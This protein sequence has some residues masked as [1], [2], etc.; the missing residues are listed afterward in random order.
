MYAVKPEANAEVHNVKNIKSVTI[1]LYNLENTQE[2]MVNAEMENIKIFLWYMHMY[3]SQFKPLRL[4]G[5]SGKLKYKKKYTL[6]HVSLAFYLL[7]QT[8]DNI[9]ILIHFQSL[10]PSSSLPCSL[11][12]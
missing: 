7:N 12:I 2:L 3:S 4:Q 10:A 11:A 8:L 1:N 9:Y 5:I 6:D